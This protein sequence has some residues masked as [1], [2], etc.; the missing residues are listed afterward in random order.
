M[1]INEKIVYLALHK[2]GCSHVLKLLTS[3]PDLNG[4]I[5]GKHNTIYEVPKKRLGDL[6]KKVKSGNVRNPW[7]WYVSLWSFGCMKKGGLYASIIKKNA[8]K[9]IIHPRAFLTPVKHWQKVYSDAENPEL[10]KQWLEMLLSSRRRDVISFGDAHVPDIMGFMTY[11]Y[12][13]LYTYQF[14]KNIKTLQIFQ[15]IKEFDRANN[16]IDHFIYMENLENNFR[17]LMIKTGIPE[18]ITDGVLKIPKTNSSLRKHYRDYYD[19]KTRELV[20][21]KEQ[22]IIEKHN[23]EF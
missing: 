22:L 19:E 3:I 6:S 15:H 20:R 2:T 14:E 21:E 7:D 17:S 12:L 5:I 4:R 13:Q 11:G 23:Y 9:K 8:F 18:N 1:Y 16:F 10:F